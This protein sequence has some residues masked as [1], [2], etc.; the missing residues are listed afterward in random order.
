MS[1]KEAQRFFY[2]WWV[3]VASF[4]IVFFGAGIGFYSFS[5]FIKPLQAEFG[6]SRAQ[7][8]GSV[9]VWAVV[10]GFSTP[11]IGIL[12][13]KYGARVVISG[14][15]LIAGICYLFFGWLDRLPELFAIMFFTGIGMAGI[16]L[17]PN[18]AVI[19]NWFQKYRGR[20]MGIMMMGVGFGGLIMPPI[21]NAIIVSLGWRT[22]FRVLGFL[23]IFVIIPV[24]ILIL[25]TKPS[26]MGL[27][28]DGDSSSQGAESSTSGGSAWGETG[29]SVKR[30][31]HT[32][33]FRL[34]FA[35]FMLL[36]FGESGLAVHFVA[37]VDDAGMTSQAAAN[38]WGL[39][40][41]V[42]A[43]GRLGAGLLAD[44][45]NQRVL[46]AFTHGL[47]AVAL[48]IL[49][50]FFMYLGIHSWIAV[51]PFCVLYGL[52]LGGAA[53]VL[54]VFVARCF[55]LLNFSKL[56]GLLMSGFALGVVGGPVVA[57]NIVDATGSYR[58]AFAIF[59]VA[60]ALSAFLVSLVQPDKYKGEF[61][62]P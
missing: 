41:G 46:L 9:A 27:R 48:A 29:L 7:I 11:V 59:T 30:A 49:L 60:F 35:G 25:R 58:L 19:S 40:V 24:A 18:Q 14:S 23:L 52:S 39:L 53:V 1:D 26:E 20:A 56:L 32:S 12:L 6:W 22:S 2:G 45:W 4:F 8:S 44:R 36:I 55:G 31:V 51:V 61:G 15:A 3:V 38:Y 43:I 21:A 33:S 16:T 50:I 62:N 17:L 28:P 37:S 13:H 10:Y 47:H 34:L 57:G 5:V 42:S 54:P